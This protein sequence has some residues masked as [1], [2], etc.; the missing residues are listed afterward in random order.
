V[1]LGKRVVVDFDV[2][3]LAIFLAHLLKEFSVNVIIEASKHDFSL[4]WS[5]NIIL[6][7]L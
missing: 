4:R 7:D 3:N 2:F 6:V 1:F 5:A